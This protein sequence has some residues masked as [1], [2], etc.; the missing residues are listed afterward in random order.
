MPSPTP[1]RR[2]FLA[3][4]AAVA[5][6]LP[7]VASA[8][9]PV[10]PEEDFQR[11]DDALVLSGGGARGV[12]QAGIIEYLRL[13]RGIVDGQP[14]AP[15]G[16]IAGTSIGALNGYFV[17][18]GQYTLLRSLWYAIAEQHVIRLKARYAKVVNAE[19]GIGTRFAAAIRL[20]LSLTSHETGVIDGDH[21][22]A[23]LASYIDPTRPPL[24][25]LV[26]SVTNLTTQS[27]EFFYLLPS[28]L[29]ADEHARAVAAVQNTVGPHV[30]LR[31]AT[32]PLLIDA[33]R[34]STAI[35]VAFDPV[36]LPAADGRGTND[37]VDG[38]VIANTPVAI[39]RAGAKRIDVVMMDPP[40]ETNT[41]DNA[42]DI[43]IGV[44][45]AMQQRILEADLRAAYFE[46]IGARA[47]R[48]PRSPQLQAFAER[49]YATDIYRLRPEQMLTVSVIGFDDRNALFETYKTGFADGRRGFTKYVY[50]SD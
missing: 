27:P 39:A 32:P 29:T 22:R 16:F 31:E 44:F 17:A 5:A 15:F 40:Q 33:L 38:G 20:A 13:S 34:A 25:P 35:P 28:R 45:G 9:L 21:V 49:L 4:A 19:S 10:L 47:I 1:D 46:T 8:E 12:Y 24:V 3:G 50:G 2:S 23:W 26:W 37:Y 18:T 36:K 6:A 42:F 48:D 30:A 11:V 14:L 7:A 41:Y 43:G